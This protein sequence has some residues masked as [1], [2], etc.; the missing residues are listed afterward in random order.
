MSFGTTGSQWQR[1]YLDALSK[2]AVK[3]NKAHV[4][5]VASIGNNGAGPCTEPGNL[6]SDLVYG[7]GATRKDGRRA[8]FSSYSDQD[9]K[10]DLSAS[11]TNVPLAVPGNGYIISHGTSL[12]AAYVSGLC[13]RLIESG[14][15]HGNGLS[16][17]NSLVSL[18]L[19]S[20]DSTYAC[21]KC[22]AGNARMPENN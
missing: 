3:G 19:S 6:P 1:H 16:L 17:R 4:L 7:I 12:S 20:A 15:P 10:P 8:S 22:G 11:G 2:K 21:E 5:I 14:L 13:A 9:Q 18:L